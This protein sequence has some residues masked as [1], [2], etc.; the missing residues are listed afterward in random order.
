MN[1]N[2]IS[3]KNIE[4]LEKTLD[5]LSLKIII[6]DSIADDI[7]SLLTTIIDSNE[8]LL[9]D[10]S[11]KILFFIFSNWE[12]VSSEQKELLLP[13]LENIYPTIAKWYSIYLISTILGEL[14]QNNQS[15]EALCRLKTI[16]D[17]ERRA[18]VAFGIGEIAR[19]KKNTDLG[20]KAL[21]I[22]TEMKSDSSK[23]VKHEVELAFQRLKD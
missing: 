2:Y 3:L 11:D 10:N 20:E 1:S 6:S 14:Y 15:F 18:L 19:Y 9:S 12:F 4:E 22:I 8:F 7:F 21:K 5:E 17:D 16:S 23:K 13:K